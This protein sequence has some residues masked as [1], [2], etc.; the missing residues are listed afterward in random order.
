MVPSLPTEK[1]T[2]LIMF[3][4]EKA[5]RNAYYFWFLRICCRQGHA[6]AV[7]AN[8][9]F[10]PLIALEGGCHSRRAGMCMA[11]PVQS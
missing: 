3:S 11:V 5:A 4:I 10:P 1:Q 6:V 9:A 2:E 7:G 8:T